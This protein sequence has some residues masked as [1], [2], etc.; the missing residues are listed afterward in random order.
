MTC[1]DV[2]AV[3]EHQTCGGGSQEGRTL[4]AHC[5]EINISDSDELVWI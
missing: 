5:D 4:R 3:A 2:Q 1:E